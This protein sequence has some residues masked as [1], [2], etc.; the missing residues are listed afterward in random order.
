MKYCP[1]L[2]SPAFCPQRFVRLVH[3]YTICSYRVLCCGFG[4]CNNTDFALH[5][6][7]ILYVITLYTVFCYFHFGLL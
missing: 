1:V 6:K 7:H 3:M 2:W 5:F 4:T